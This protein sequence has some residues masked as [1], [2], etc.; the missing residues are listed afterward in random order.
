MPERRWIDR[1]TG[2]QD[3]GDT[4]SLIALVA[5]N[6]V[7]LIG[8]VCLGWDVAAILILYW[9][10][11]L[12]VGG[13][14]ILKMIIAR[15]DRADPHLTKLVL[16][17]FFCIHYGGF[18][19]GHGFLLM[20]LL[21]MGDGSIELGPPPGT[22]DLLVPIHLLCAVVGYVW[23]CGPEGMVWPV[24][25]LAAS[26]GVSFLQNYL[27]KREYASLSARALMLRPYGR[28]MLLHVVIIAGAVPL[29]LFG[30]PLPLLVLLIVFKIIVDIRLHTKSHTSSRES[31]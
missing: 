10:E 18:C 17:P 2:G 9:A 1:L 11:N 27:M 6:C 8:V 29:M 13:Y 22:P 30:S 20:A 5:A 3:R 14:T 4:I 25:G 7:P 31:D 26:H 19:A 15:A 12:V 28:V 16:I 23:R 24:A 21:R